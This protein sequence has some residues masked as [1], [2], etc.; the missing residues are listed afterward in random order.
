MIFGIIFAYLVLGLVIGLLSKESEFDEGWRVLLWFVGWPVLGILVNRREDVVEDVVED[1]L[2]KEEDDLELH[3][4]FLAIMSRDLD[5]Y[6]REKYSYPKVGNPDECDG[7]MLRDLTDADNDHI[8]TCLKCRRSYVEGSD[9]R[10]EYSDYYIAE[11][12]K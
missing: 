8:L 12:E 6:L 5:E 4:K 11:E 9:E 7:C 3:N 2:E 1:G 10:E